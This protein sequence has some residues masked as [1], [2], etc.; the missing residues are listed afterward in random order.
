VAF[1]PD[2]AY[3]LVPNRWDGTLSVIDTDVASVIETIPVGADPMIVATS[4]CLDKAYLTNRGSDSVS[5][6]DTSGLTV[7]KTITGFYS[8]WGIVLSP[9]GRWAYVANQGDGTIGV[10]NTATDDLIATWD[11]HGG[12]LQM[13]DISPEAH[14]MLSMLIGGSAGGRCCA[15][16]MLDVI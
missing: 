14:S 12:W 11:I 15:V 10:I 4:P 13:L 3:A 9:Y 7:T 6:I 5:V 16:E 8:P 2:G 1:T